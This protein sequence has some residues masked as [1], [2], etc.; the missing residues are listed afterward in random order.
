MRRGR[1]AVVA[2]T[3]LHGLTLTRRLSDQVDGWLISLAS[4]LP[5]GW[6]VA[7]T[8]GYGRGQLY[9]AG[10]VDALLLHPRGAS[11]TDVEAMSRR[12]W[13]PFW[14]S[15]IKLSPAVHDDRSLLQLANAELF[16]QT[17]LLE[18]RL[19]AGDADAVAFVRDAALG[20]WRKHPW[21]W[22]ERLL[23]ANRNRWKASGDVASR[24]EPNLKDGRGGLRDVDALRWALLTGRADVERAF[25]AP[26][27]DAAVAASTIAAVR[28]E[29]HRVTGR[30]ANILLLQ[31]QDAVAAATGYDDAD[32]MMATVSAAARQVE[33]LSERF[34]DRASRMIDRRGR[35]IRGSHG[36]ERGRQRIGHLASALISRDGEVELAASADLTDPS[37][38]FRAAEAAARHGLRLARSTL[39]Q[40]A[41]APIGAGQDWTTEMRQAFLGMLGAGMPLIGVA[42]ALEHHGLLSR[43]LPEWTAV[44]SRPQR[45]AFH[46]YTVDRHLLQTVVEAHQL[47]RT[48]SRPDLLLLGALLHDIGKGSPGDHT[49]AGVALVAP[50]AQ[51]MGFDADD[52][53]TLRIL[54]QTHLL[55]AE[56]ATR[57][58]LDDPRTAQLVAERVGSL[59]RLHLLR[60]LTEADSKATGPTGW[61]DWKAE[62]INLLT[63]R[64]AE[65]L[66]DG[67]APRP[68]PVPPN[69]VTELV[70]KV[71]ATAN[72]QVSRGRGAGVDTIAVAF[73]D[74]PGLFATVAGSLACHGIEVIAADVWTTADGVAVDQFQIPRRT[75]ADLAKLQRFLEDALD[76]TIDVDERVAQRITS[77]TRRRMLAAAPAQREIVVSNHESRSTTMIEVRSPDAEAV[78]YRLANVL[79]RFELDIVSAKV[80]TLGH[81]VVDVFYVRCANQRDSPQLHESR[82]ADLA[83]ALSAALL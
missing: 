70:D 29:L 80:A 55:L 21:R 67:P 25:D 45:N 41:N 43:F 4:D 57:R 44:R 74:R 76:E 82:H 13:Y 58:D 83:T 61:N 33:W 7:A 15:G 10:D 39:V 38:T 59:H 40:L 79:H 23:D 14:D 35:G 18:L 34:W 2:D 56:T 53:E 51:R 75:I 16:T 73:P 19:V 47:L 9:P 37:L 17:S 64:T 52:T 24:L 77:Q 42:D 46:V 65:C 5:D 60:A 3:G 20:L 68:R 81:E 69:D 6:A 12:L 50:I 48:V 1:E 72:V 63:A 22:L 11:A 8:G 62:L 30:A 26:I 32:Q 36:G 49:E 28:A 31:D 27:D 78:L 71:R 66:L 54:V